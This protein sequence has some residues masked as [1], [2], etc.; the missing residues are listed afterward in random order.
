MS[1]RPSDANDRQATI[2]RL[3]ARRVVDSEL[4][5]LLWLLLGAGIGLVVSGRPASGRDALAAALEQ[6][7][8]Q[9]AKNNGGSGR[10]AWL[11]EAE[12][13]EAVFD[14]LTAPEIGLQPDQLR[15]LGLVVIVR[16]VAG[17]GSRVI[18]AHYVRPPERDAG[19]HV[20]RRPPAVLA[21]LDEHAGRLDH[22]AWGVLP[23][24]AERSGLSNVDFDR[25]LA[26]R[27]ELIDRL[28]GA[29]ELSAAQLSGAVSALAEGER[30]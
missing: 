13:L 3:V 6:L 25:R 26:A 4:A 20:Q 27:R 10:A 9:A 1:A 18:A 30:H 22:F 21:A 23:E 12:S 5:A 2:T 19:G 8:G 11:L 17:L 16:D 29:G 15:L 28:V 7:V 24:L 14:Q